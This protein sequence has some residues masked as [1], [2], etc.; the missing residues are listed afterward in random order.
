MTLKSDEL[1]E[2]P[3]NPPN[4][5]NYGVMGNIFEKLRVDPETDPDFKGSN[6][7]VTFHLNDG[8]HIFDINK[9]PYSSVSF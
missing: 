7:E 4:T 9:W 8:N 3:Y 6:E 5:S 1:N 2:N